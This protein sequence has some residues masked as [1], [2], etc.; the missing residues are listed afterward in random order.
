MSDLNADSLISSGIDEAKALSDIYFD[1]STTESLDVITQSNG[2][3]YESREP[4]QNELPSE[5]M[6]GSPLINDEIKRDSTLSTMADIVLLAQ[7][8]PKKVR[9]ST[10]FTNSAEKSKHGKIAKVN[11][12]SIVSE[13]GKGSFGLVY[14]VEDTTSD[15]ENPTLY[16]MKS[17]PGAKSSK[18][19]KLLGRVR[20]LSV[21][22]S[23]P[24]VIEPDEPPN[25]IDTEIAVMK[26]LDHPNIVRLH[27]VSSTPSDS[28]KQIIFISTLCFSR[29]SRRRSFLTLSI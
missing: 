5:S 6:P 22:S 15:P 23:T 3:S 21:T 9:A 13:I 7:K 4:Y 20:S 24:I 16:A 27:E 11:Q 19:N 10:N 17:F 1:T 28:D 25:E 14:L 18:K 12:Y 26:Q 2:S 8:S 29:L